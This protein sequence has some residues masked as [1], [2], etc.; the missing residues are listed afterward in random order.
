MADN[1][2]DCRAMG[3]YNAM[4]PGAHIGRGYIIGTSIKMMNCS[5]KSNETRLMAMIKFTV[6]LGNAFLTTIVFLQNVKA[7]IDKSYQSGH[8]SI[9]CMS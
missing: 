4:L 9:D 6:T 7:S 3:P 8:L 5:N 2:G 1:Y